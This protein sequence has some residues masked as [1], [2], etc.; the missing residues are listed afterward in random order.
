MI[1]L[2]D[3]SDSKNIPDFASP[4]EP[5]ERESEW[6]VASSGSGSLCIPEALILK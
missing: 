3:F 2:V 6:Y 1:R 4:E 5:E